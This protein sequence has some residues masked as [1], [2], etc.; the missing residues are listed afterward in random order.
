MMAEPDYFADNMEDLYTIFGMRGSE[1]VVSPLVKKAAVCDFDPKS[2][3]YLDI[4]GVRKSAATEDIPQA[5]VTEV[6]EAVRGGGEE[7]AFRR[8]SLTARSPMNTGVRTAK[9]ESAEVSP[10]TL[11]TGSLPN[12][13]GL[14]PLAQIK[15]LGTVAALDRTRPASTPL[16]DTGAEADSVILVEEPT[17]IAEGGGAD[18]ASS[19]VLAPPQGGQ[20]GQRPHVLG[21]G[22]LDLYDGGRGLHHKCRL[23]AEKEARKSTHDEHC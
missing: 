7:A 2:T 14:M 3:T 17:L 18:E 5:V 22:A 23:Q 6:V 19:A 1:V 12:V 13:G 8:S 4:P 20:E 11:R 16:E 21:V 10:G 9:K 15:R